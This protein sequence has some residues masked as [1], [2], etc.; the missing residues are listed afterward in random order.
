M[1]SENQHYN[2][3]CFVIDFH[4]YYFFHYI[5]TKFIDDKD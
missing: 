4:K 2:Q 5:N 3:F 1:S